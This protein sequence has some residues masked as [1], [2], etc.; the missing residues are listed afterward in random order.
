LNADI[1]FLQDIHTIPS[2]EDTWKLIWRGNILFSHFSSNTAVIAICFSNKLDYQILEHKII[3][4]GR[5][6]HVTVCIQEQNYHLINVYAPICPKEKVI[7][8]RSLKHHLNDLESSTPIF[9]GGDFNCTINPK[10]D[11]TGDN[12]PHPQTSAEFKH[13]VKRFKL[14]DTFRNIHPYQQTYAWKRNDSIAARIDRKYIS[15]HYCQFVRHS[16]IK[17]CDFSDHDYIRVYFKEKTVNG[18]TLIGG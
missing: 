17:N 14:N 4:P 10:L 11:R 6:L 9:L 13:I 7:F 1:V 8:L 15:K 12:E 5:I 16:E 18:E 3:L 2:E